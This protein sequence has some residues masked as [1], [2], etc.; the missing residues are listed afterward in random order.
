MHRDYE[1][2]H[3]TQLAIR[4]KSGAGP[5]TPVQESGAGEVVLRPDPRLDLRRG[6]R[7]VADD[8]PGTVRRPPHWPSI[9]PTQAAKPVQAT[10]TPAPTGVVSVTR[11]PGPEPTVPDNAQPFPMPTVNPTGGA[12]RRDGG[13]DGSARLPAGGRAGPR[14]DARARRDGRA[15]AGLGQAVRDLAGAVHDRPPRQRGGRA[16]GDGD[17]GREGDADGPVLRPGLPALVAVRTVDGLIGDSLFSRRC[18]GPASGPPAERGSRRSSGWNRAHRARRGSHW[19]A[20]HREGC[21][22]SS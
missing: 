17:A 4:R 21:T 3:Q 20:R 18:P 5:T 22:W 11:T 13:A 14:A 1:P 16:R 12:A 10:P 2:N 19:D 9:A 15:D 8:D 7:P 6:E